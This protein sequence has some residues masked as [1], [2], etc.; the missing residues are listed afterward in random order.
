MAG[1]RADRELRAET[2]I[3]ASPE[4][5]WAVL[6]DLDRMP[7]LSPELVRM[8]ALKKGGLRA[9][10]AYLGINRRKWVVWPS[11]SVVRSVIP[12]RELVWDTRT[13]GAR[14][15][16]ELTPEGDGTRVV[17]RR[18]VPSGLAL[19]SRAFAPVLLGGGD[20]HADELEQGMVQTLSR[21]K[22]AVEV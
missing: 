14:W 7:D 13:S 22:A 10:Q 11:R 4:Q 17:H 2:S 5:V 16:Y 20:S 19:I 15:I 21:L 3:A 9:G 18:P 8:V 1:V 6:A 12:A